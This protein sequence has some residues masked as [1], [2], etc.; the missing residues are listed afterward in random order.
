MSHLIQIKQRIRAIEKTKK[1][2]RAMRLIAMSLYSKLEKQKAHLNTYNETVVSL[3]SLIAQ[4]EDYLPSFFTPEDALN[5]HPLIILATSTKALCGA[6]NN[7]IIRYFHK[8]FLL[9]KH[10][11][12]S[13]VALGSRAISL[14]NTRPSGKIL[15][16]ASECTIATI[17]TIAQNITQLICTALP[18]YTSVTV[19]HTY[20]KGFFVQIPV[21]TTL[22]PL[23]LKTTPEKPKPST[24]SYLWEQNPQAVTS[25]IATHY[26]YTSIVRTLFHSLISE[27]A[28][29]F[30]AMDQSTSNADKY[31]ET[32]SID[33]NKSR[34]NLITRE[35]AELA[36][37]MG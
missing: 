32:L 30:I 11:R 2:T 25:H 8:T 35:I 23:D 37:N 15:Y 20:L 5:S 19:Y 9:E 13:F 12:A 27:N 34:Q 4:Y 7:N 33:Y 26:L 24:V 36:A 14:L 17:P 22:I 16:N 18:A 28:A 31:L 21:R 3:T 29:R 1:I 10:Q 6:L